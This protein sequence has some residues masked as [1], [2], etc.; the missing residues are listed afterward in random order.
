MSAPAARA[1]ARNTAEI[2]R[3]SGKSDANSA[4]VSPCEC[5]RVSLR[6]E[7]GCA[8]LPY[9]IDP[10][11]DGQREQAEQLNHQL[12][13]RAIALGG[14]CTGEHGIGVHKQGFLL[15]EAGDGAVAMMRAIKQALDPKN[16]LNPGKIFP[17]G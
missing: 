1:R 4:S 2:G 9:L 8:D 10:D 6:H 13:Q 3:K 16:I 12:V 11:N 14:T 15:E 17:L 7:A 5:S